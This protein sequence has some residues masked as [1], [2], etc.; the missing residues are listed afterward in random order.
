MGDLILHLI[1][2][3][4]ITA[5]ILLLKKS[6]VGRRPDWLVILAVGASLLAGV[7]KEA[8]DKFLGWGTPEIADITFTWSGGMFALMVIALIDWLQY[9]SQFK[10]V[11]RTILDKGVVHRIWIYIAVLIALIFSMKFI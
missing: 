7:V 3:A 6:V 9:R 10:Y 2:G 5:V 4:A 1:V 11:E 8:A